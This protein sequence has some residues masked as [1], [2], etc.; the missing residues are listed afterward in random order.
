MVKRY[1]KKP[2]E[3]E[4]VKWTGENHEEINDFCSDLIG[5]NPDESGIAYNDPEGHVIIQTLEGK[6]AASVGDYIVKG[7]KGEFYPVKPDIFHETY[8]EVDN[9]EN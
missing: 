8:E 7:V 3:I 9:G 5:E 1:R 4:A 6:V 2:V